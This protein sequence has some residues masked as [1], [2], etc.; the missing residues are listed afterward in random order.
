M[1]PTRNNCNN[2]ACIPVR[3]LSPLTLLPPQLVRNVCAEAV[4]RVRVIEAAAVQMLRS[5]RSESAE[6]QHRIR[7]VKQQRSPCSL[8]RQ[9]GCCS[10]VQQQLCSI[11]FAAACNS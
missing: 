6:Q 11:L 10:A 5:L 8:I 9:R 7:S 1:L 4:R 3:S 2:C